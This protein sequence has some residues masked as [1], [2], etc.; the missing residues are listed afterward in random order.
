VLQQITVSNLTPND[1]EKIRAIFDA[2]EVKRVATW[3]F[4]I[5]DSKVTLTIEGPVHSKDSDVLQYAIDMLEVAK[6]N[7]MC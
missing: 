4:P 2:V 6:K 5:G 3:S 7:S 1:V